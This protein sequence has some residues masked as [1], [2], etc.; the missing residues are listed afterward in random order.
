MSA[1]RILFLCTGNA[2]RSQMGEGWLRHLAG[3]RVEVLSAGTSPHGVNATAVEVM[4]EVG[5]DLSEH[6]SDDVAR[7][8]DE[9]LA[10]VIAVCDNAAEACPRFA[11]AVPILRWPFPDPAGATGTRDEVL[12]AFRTVRD[13]IRTRIEAWIEAD[14]E[15]LALP[16]AE[17]LSG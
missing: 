7:Y 14:F 6:S 8:L 5:V 3:D 10:A 15:P 16:G 13:A 17:P 11:H 4:G 12:D 9:P 2:C 1:P